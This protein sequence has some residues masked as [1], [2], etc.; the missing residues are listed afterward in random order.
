MILF[1]ESK[2]FKNWDSDIDEQEMAEKFN[3]EKEDVI[4]FCWGKS[5][6]VNLTL[7]HLRNW[8]GDVAGLRAT[9][10][11]KF[12]WIVDFPLFVKSDSGKLESAHHPFTASI[13]E[14]V[15]RLWKMTDLDNITGKS[16]L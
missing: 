7:G 3:I 9:K 4:V 16:Y 5:N 1:H 11:F 10:A 15:D 12:L 14:D 8:L 2:W 6:E 13:A